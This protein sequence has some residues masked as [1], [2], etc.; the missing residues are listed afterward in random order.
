MLK[1]FVKG[2]LSKCDISF[3]DLAA[4]LVVNL[5]NFIQQRGIQISIIFYITYLYGVLFLN[6]ILQ[7][8]F[9]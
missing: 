4:K 3:W 6:E 7:I 1:D 5:N 2:K 8:F 9:G